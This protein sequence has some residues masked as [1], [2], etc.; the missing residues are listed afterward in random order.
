M[1]VNVYI[2]FSNIWIEGQR[3]SAV[4][5]GLAADQREAIRRKILAPWYPDFRKLFS[6][7]CPVY[8]KIG[9]AAI[10]GSRPPASDPLWGQAAA[11]GFAVKVV[12]DAGRETQVDSAIDAMIRYDASKCIQPGRGDVVVL[13]SGDGGFVPT[14]RAVQELGA[15][16]RVASWRHAASFRLRR[17]ADE[18]LALD[19]YFAYL[20]LGRNEDMAA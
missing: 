13:V 9:R 5:M 3:C 7:I 6:V 18:F 8:A 20:T 1:I 17:A 19:P 10:F 2:D 12:E 11:A 14:I 4:N 15:T 16:V